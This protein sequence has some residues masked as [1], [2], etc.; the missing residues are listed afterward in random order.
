MGT[1]AGRPPVFWDGLTGQVQFFRA[2]L[3]RSARCRSGT[4]KTNWDSRGTA[5]GFLDAVSAFVRRPTWL[6]RL[7]P[8]E[9]DHR[10][11][12]PPIGS[13]ERVLVNASPDA[14]RFRHGLRLIQPVDPILP[15]PAGH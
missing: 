8:A 14:G 10:P 15:A 1:A 13:I 11:R 5:A 4:R 7:T 12:D 6:S 9:A 2:L 3:P